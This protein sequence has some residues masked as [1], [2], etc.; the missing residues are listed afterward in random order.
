[1]K[2][3]LLRLSIAL[4]TFFI[5]ISLTSV[6]LFFARIPNI[7]VIDELVRTNSHHVDRGIEIE[8][9][10]TLMYKPERNG[11]FIVTNNTTESIYYL[12]YE[13]NQH[14]DNWIKQNGKSQAATDF[15]CRMGMKEQEIK[16][17]GSA[18]FEITVPSNNKP[19]EAGFDFFIGDSQQPKTLW[20]KVNQQSKYLAVHQNSK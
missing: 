4:F 18:F 16:P 12:A 5:G 1:M 17:N 2:R 8:Y 19:F 15:V 11:F 7:E 3:F 13:R 20:V 10:W 14:F 9:K 6:F